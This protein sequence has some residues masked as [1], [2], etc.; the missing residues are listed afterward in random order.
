[1][2]ISP[3]A[4]QL[5]SF[6][7]PLRSTPNPYDLPQ[8][9]KRKI[10]KSNLSYPCAHWNMRKLPVTGPSKKAESSPTP[11]CQKP[12]SVNR[13]SFSFPA[14]VFKIKPNL[15]IRLLDYLILNMANR[16]DELLILKVQNQKVHF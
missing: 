8:N 5:Y 1:M 4:P 7:S 3:K 12:S 11:P 9:K 14:T 6:S 10:T 13:C 15:I 2:E 16:M